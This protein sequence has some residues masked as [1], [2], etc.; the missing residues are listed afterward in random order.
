MSDQK[1]LVYM[2]LGAAGSGRRQVLL[3]LIADGL[4]DDANP[5]VLLHEGESEA[6]ADEQLPALERWRWSGSTIEGDI[7]MQATHVF[8]IADGRANPVDQLGEAHSAMLVWY[9]ACVHFSDVVLLN[10]REGVSNKWISDFQSR[11]REQCLPCLMEFVKRGR[12]KSASV[13]LDPVALRLSHYFDEEQDWI[14]S[15][16]VDEDEAEG[17][18][19]IEV[20]LEQD[21]YLERHGGDGRRVKEIPNVA[22]Y[23]SFEE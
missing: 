5:E 1:P 17:D 9:D 18:E 2:I 10:Q 3:D 12:V 6:P 21:I 13:V 22:K 11:Y 19:E 20:A 14:I 15:G 23:L 8:L 16:A 4:P 7:S